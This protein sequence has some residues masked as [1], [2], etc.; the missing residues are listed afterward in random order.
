MVLVE[1]ETIVPGYLADRRRQAGGWVY[2]L[3][4]AA[5]RPGREALDRVARG[6]GIK[7]GSL[8]PDVKLARAVEVITG[9]CGGEALRVL[10]TP[11]N[12]FTEKVIRSFGAMGPERQA[13]AM[14]RATRGGDPLAR[15]DE[16]DWP[17]DT[18]RFGE[19]IGRLARALGDVAFNLR[20]VPRMSP[21]LRPTP[22]EKADIL[23]HLAGITSLSPQL[24]RLVEARGT[25]AGAAAGGPG[26]PGDEVKPLKTE[27][28]AQVRG[29]ADTAHY[30]ID[31]C[32]HDVPRLGP[33]V[34]PT[35]RQAA[36][37]R[38]KLLALADRSRAHRDLVTGMPTSAP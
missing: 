3:S 21:D 8:K 37:I 29:R 12:R 2:E 30:F 19:V 24:L 16:G 6:Y 5:G 9:N 13:Y 35:P 7:A 17:M 34:R 11:G 31:K 4:F 32:V 28:F 23:R 18:R 33:G 1:V 10:L 36:A 22:S 15:P 26:G 38:A 25:T 20:D 27:T 14:P